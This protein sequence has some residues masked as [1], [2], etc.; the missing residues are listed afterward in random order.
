MAQAM[1]K[2]VREAGNEDRR[3][4]G[5]RGRRARLLS[6]GYVMM[7]DTKERWIPKP[8]DAMSAP[9]FVTAHSHR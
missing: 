9:L 5:P 1:G 4:C 7:W 8:E 6:A 3:F 2:L